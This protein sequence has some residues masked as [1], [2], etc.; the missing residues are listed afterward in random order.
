MFYSVQSASKIET[1]LLRQFVLSSVLRVK[2]ALLVSTPFL[3]LSESRN[4][5]VASFPKYQIQFAVC[6]FH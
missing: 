5:L 3:F 4:S 6:T 2:V 1:I